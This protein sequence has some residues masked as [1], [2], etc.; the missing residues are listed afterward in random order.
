MTQS[1][2]NPTEDLL[3][4][5]GEALV[6]THGRERSL[7]AVRSLVQLE[8]QDWQMDCGADSA[9]AGAARSEQPL[10]GHRIRLSSD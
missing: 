8:I 5:L 1:P 9:V 7:D 2:H 4:R 10:I 3:G 6:G